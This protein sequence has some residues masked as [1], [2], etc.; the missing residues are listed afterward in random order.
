MNDKQTLI[1]LPGLLCDDA[2]WRNQ[3]EYLSDLADVRIAD[4]TKA[5]SMAVL[6][7]TV[8]DDAPDT[9]ALAGLSMG[10]Y[11]AQEIMR[12]APERVSR[13]ALLDTNARA[14]LP[15]QTAN[16]KRLIAQAESGE[17]WAIA[18]EMLPNLVYDR[19]LVLTGIRDTVLHMAERVGKDAFV[20]QQTAIMDRIDGRASLAAIDCPVLVLCGRNDALTPILVH[21]EMA[22]GIG[23]NAVLVVIPNSGHLSPIEQPGA[24][25]TALRDW[26]MR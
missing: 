2:L 8:L 17:F 10:G 7:Q 26:L 20:R 6:A 23:D 3:V 5:E 9:F 15:E 11:V 12:Q 14:D 21:E 18:P 22:E 13:L 25:T 24:V 16:R 1:L 4:L 19:H